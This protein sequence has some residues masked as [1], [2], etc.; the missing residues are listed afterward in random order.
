M[1]QLNIPVYLFFV[2]LLMIIVP[3][4]IGYNLLAIQEDPV[5]LF[6]IFFKKCLFTSVGSYLRPVGSFV[7]TFSSCGVQALEH[8]G[9][10]ALQHAR[11]WSPS[12]GPNPCPQHCKVESQPLDPQ[13]VLSV[14]V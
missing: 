10:V 9:L 12:Q 3:K 7:E 4:D 8:V 5:S 2:I 6:Y 11:C 1:T 14:Q 13:E